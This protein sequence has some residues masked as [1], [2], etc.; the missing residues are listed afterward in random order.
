[1]SSVKRGSD[2][3][4]VQDVDIKKKAKKMGLV[5]VAKYNY[6][7]GIL[8]VSK[9]YINVLIHTKSQKQEL[10]KQLSPYV[11]K[12]INEQLIENVWQFS[13]IYPTVYKQRQSIHRNQ[14]NVIVWEHDQEQHYIND[15][16]TDSYWKWREKG[17]N[18]WY[19]VRYPNG[20]KGRHEC[21]GCIVGTKDDYKIL[22]YI[23]SRKAVYCKEYIDSAPLTDDF[24]TLKSM[25]NNGKNLQLI[26]VDGPDYNL[27][28]APY[29][30]ISKD[31]PG[32]DITEDTIKMLLNDPRKPF[33]HGYV[34]AA[35]LLD[36]QEW[37]H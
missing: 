12:N 27:N 30:Q 28:Y 17:M 7:T 13:K 10:G 21:K 20:F 4:K 1:M 24:K 32:L 31:N 33:G 11:L 22:G 5:K 8:P 34:V 16:P 15:K 6:K 37:L 35:L 2:V 26:E 14:P 3:I 19:A 18:N 23:E 36:G 25:L 29:D 9:G